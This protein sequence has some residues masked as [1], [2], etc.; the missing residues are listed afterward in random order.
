MYFSDY[1]DDND[2]DV[3]HS[4]TMTTTLLLTREDN[5]RKNEQS[6]IDA[7]TQMRVWLT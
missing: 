7:Q 5:C 1:E 6:Q 2:G 3:A 4:N